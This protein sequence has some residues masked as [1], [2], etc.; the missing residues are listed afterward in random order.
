MDEFG[1]RFVES[2]PQP[3]INGGD[4]NQWHRATGD[5]AF[6]DDF[7][8]AHLRIERTSRCGA[9]A[10]GDPRGGGLLERLAASETEM[11][12]ERAASKTSSKRCRAT[13]STAAVCL[14]HTE[15]RGEGWSVANE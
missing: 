12:E 3:N 1:Y 15:L 4:V 5:G 2:A 11:G 13:V 6:R 7:D 9:S 8:D 14:A 10:G